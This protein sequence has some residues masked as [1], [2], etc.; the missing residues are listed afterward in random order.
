M[1]DL[2]QYYRFAWKNGDDQASA[3]Y[4]RFVE[5]LKSLDRR[6]ERCP[7]ARL[8]VNQSECFWKFGNCTLVASQMSF[9]SCLPSTVTLY[10]FFASFVRNDAA[11]RGDRLK[12]PTLRSDRGYQS[13]NGF[14]S[15][16]L[17][18]EGKDAAITDSGK[19]ASS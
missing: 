10:A 12:D 18:D 8:P 13:W 3:W 11:H 19:H 16:S 2:E 1:A 5:Q 17:Q 6:P 9:E 15:K 14:R 4:E 7:I